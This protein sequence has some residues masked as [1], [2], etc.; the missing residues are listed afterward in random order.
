[1]DSLFGS[2]RIRPH[3][4]HEY[5]PTVLVV[6]IQ[7][8]TCAI[9]RPIHSVECGCLVLNMP[10]IK[11]VLCTCYAGWTP[12][13]DV[14]SALEYKWAERKCEPACRS[15]FWA[16]ATRIFCIFN[17]WWRC[18]F[19]KPC[20]LFILNNMWCT[21]LLACMCVQQ[22][23]LRRLNFVATCTCMSRDSRQGFFQAT[24]QAWYQYSVHS[25]REWH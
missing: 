3:I 1:M 22:F 15:Q 16:I 4:F 13:E 5:Q 18:M 9:L 25:G 2:F 19:N 10:P 21:E 14:S 6:W 12:L 24:N 8:D 23:E 11:L 20:A 17:C 7:E